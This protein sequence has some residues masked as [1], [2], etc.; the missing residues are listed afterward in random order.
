MRLLGE[1]R[2]AGSRTGLTSKQAEE[3]LRCLM[4]G[5]PSC[6][7]LTD[8]APRYLDHLKV[9]GTR[10]STIDDY[11]TWLRLHLLPF[12]GSRPLNQVSALDVE[13]YMSAELAAGASRK[14]VRNYLTLLHGMFRY[15]QR[16]DYVPSNPLHLVDRPHARRDPDIRYLDLVDLELI[17]DSVPDDLLGPTDRV[18]YLAA[19]L[20]GLRRGELL[21]LRWR[22]VDWSTRVVRVRRSFARGQ[23]GPGKSRAGRSVPL[24]TRMLRELDAHFQRSAFKAKD[25]LIFPHPARGSVYDPSTL[26]KRFGEVVRALR[27]RP[28]RFHDLRH[29]FGTQMA[30]AGAPMRSIQEWMGHRD[31]RATSIYVDYAPDPGGALDIADRAFP[32]EDPVERGS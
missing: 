6:P 9:R 4:M 16:R 21:A 17:L 20:T 14:S 23:F 29:T 18:L 10:E 26:R 12:F 3:K 5:S 27:M 7:S 11:E 19:A 25:D 30:A 2:Q 31:Y 22:D 24:A 32:D 1:R 13:E 28:I 8:I 15:A